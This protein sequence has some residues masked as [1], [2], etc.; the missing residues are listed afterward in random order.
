MQVC[1]VGKAFQVEG[2]EDREPLSHDIFESLRSSKR[3]GQESWSR[4]MEAERCV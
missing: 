4:V 2:R 1:E 3:A